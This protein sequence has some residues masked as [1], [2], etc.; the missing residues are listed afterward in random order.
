MIFFGE[1]GI[2]DT[3][4]NQIAD[5]AKLSYTEDES[6]LD[7]ITFIDESV[8]TINGNNCKD[9]VYGTKSLSELECVVE[10]IGNLKSLCAWLREAVAAHQRLLMEIKKYQVTDYAKDN[11]IVI[12]KMPQIELPLTEDDVI[13]T[14]DIKKRNRYYWLEAMAVTIGQIVHKNG[15]FDKARKRYYEKLSHPR[16]A[17]GTGNDMLIYTYT[18]SISKEEIEDTFYGLQQ[19]HSSYQ[20]ELNSIKA[21]IK[22]RL[23]ND[24]IDRTRKYE[25][26]F[27]KY[28]DEYSKIVNQF[29][30]WKAAEQKRIASLK[31]VIPNALKDIFESVA[32][33]GKK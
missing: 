1:E 25:E 24:E 18:P 10:C 23:T 28:T 3:K 31:I 29:N 14:F 6:Y 26:D 5:F 22:S 8:E 7:S 19:K 17:I 20:S 2:T 21:E 16:N 33:T 13:A 4:A 9:L 32:S 12:P 27:Q 11:N 15:S 30:S